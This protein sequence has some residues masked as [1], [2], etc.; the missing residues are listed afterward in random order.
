MFSFLLEIV[1]PER[2]V[3]SDQVEMVVVPS[4]LGTAGILP[5]HTPFFSK[6]EHGELKIKKSREEYY[7]SIGGGFVE[8]T[9]EKV[10]VLVTRAI[11]ASEL[12]EQE[13]IRAKKE[14][15]EALKKKPAGEAWISAQTILR[16]SLV[17]LRILRRRRRAFH[18]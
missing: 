17:D 11:N 15:E 16:Q 18:N 1:T 10:M 12:E 13:I 4:S 8:V 14:A 6:L 3:Y 7:L 9:R 5:R 2:I